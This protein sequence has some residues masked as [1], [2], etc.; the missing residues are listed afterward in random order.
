MSST[1]ARKVVDSFKPFIDKNKH[2]E[3]SPREREVLEHL[4]AGYRYKDIG[5][6]LYISI[7]T[8]RSHIQKIYDKLHVN[9]RT[10]ALNKY[11]D[12]SGNGKR[13]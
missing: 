3:L 2:D 9:N 11:N 7:S 13:S 1:I 8:V 5:D 12:K 10:E 6:K 4:A